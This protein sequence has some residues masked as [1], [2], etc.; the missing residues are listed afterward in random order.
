MCSLECNDTVSTYAMICK[1]CSLK[2]V[3]E[4]EASQSLKA[5]ACC[6]MHACT[7]CRNNSLHRSQLEKILMRLPVTLHISRCIC[8]ILEIH[9]PC[10]IPYTSCGQ[11]AHIAFTLCAGKYT[12]SEA[13]RT[14]IDVVPSC[15]CFFAFAVGICSLCLSVVVTCARSS[16]L[17]YTFKVNQ[18][19]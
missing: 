12:A 1:T 11:Q 18:P 17:K 8:R 9:N 13:T 19:E 14:A 16:P 15:R 5:V 6:V 4:H 10:S 3:S 7:L 2:A